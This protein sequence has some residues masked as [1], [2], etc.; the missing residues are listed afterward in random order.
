V[1]ATCA[2]MGQAA[3]TAAALC[4]KHGVTPRGLYQ[5]KAKL[6][7]LQQRLLSDDQSIIGLRNEDSRDL[8]RSAKVTA[9]DAAQGSK[10]EAVISGITRDVPGKLEHRWLAPIEKDGAWLEFAWD[11]PRKVSQVQITFDS[12]FQRELTLTSSDSHNKAMIRA[13]QPE[14]V[15]DYSI[16][17]RSSDG[18]ETTLAC[19][20]R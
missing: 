18:K 11:A 4:V 13:A 12:G 3:G 19:H 15:R 8:A 9:S 20:Q 10:P 1:M 17:A 16:I 14:T 5:D 6:A 2:V 7:E